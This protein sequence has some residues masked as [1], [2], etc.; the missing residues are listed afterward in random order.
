MK[1]L[2]K[3]LIPV[4]V[5]AIVGYACSR[6]AGSRYIDLSTGDGVELVKD[7]QSGLLVS[8]ETGDPIYMYVD[9]ETRDTIYGATGQVIN[10]E[11]ERLD[12]GGY[13]YVGDY[14]FKDGDYKVKVDG[15]EMK[16]KSEYQKIKTEDD[17]KKIKTET[18]K[19][20]TDEDGR[21]VKYDD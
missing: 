12:D 4:I 17:E 10:G 5:L 13:R 14:K 15:D 16:I 2:K 9:T 19:I 18:K 20:K 7:E 21:K 11:I 8:A 6:T 1:T 3:I